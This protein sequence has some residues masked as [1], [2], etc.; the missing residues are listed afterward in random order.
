AGPPPG[1][2][3]DFAAIDEYVEKEMEATRLPGV[4]LGIVRGDEIVHLEG[5]GEADPSGRPVTPKTPFII[6]STSKSFTALAIMQLVEAGE[7]ELDAPVRRYIP[8]FRVADPEA[9]GRI[10]V[11]HLLN[12]TSGLSTASG[13]AYL[14][15]E[16]SS[17][18]ALEKEV[19]G[20]ST[21]ELTAPVGEVYQY[22]NLNYTTLGLIVQRVSGEPYERYVE[23]HVLDPLNMND[24]FASPLEA[25]RRGLATGHQYW[26]GRPLPFGGLSYNRAATP[27][28]FISSS[29]EDMSHYMIAQLDGGRYGDEELLSQAGIAGLHRP[30]V[31]TGAAAGQSYAMG[32]MVQE[33][34]GVSTVWH[35]GS[36]QDFH[37]NVI[38]APERGWGIVLL[39]NGDNLLQ[40]QRIDG[41][42]AGVMSLLVGD[43]PP[44][45]PFELLRTVFFAVLAICLLQLL[46][47]ARSVVLLRRWRTQPARRPRG[48]LRVG[49]RVVG[50][51]LSNLLWAAVCL[52]GLPQGSPLWTM[53]FYDIGLVVVASGTVALVWGAISRPV[54]A[55]LVLR[56][57]DGG[58]AEIGPPKE[59]RAPVEAK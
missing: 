1:E 24:S 25:E 13:T 58:P 7:V 42:A 48:L 40:M 56:T 43:R 47:I 5:F 41:I 53:V 54:L 15:E 16:D 34:N 55:L 28:G 45:A 27:A 9:S 35:N 23:E 10:T 49:L 18:A 17:D 29:A 4:A 51:L 39:T 30:A 37:A 32:W 3:S 59:T 19:R 33:V 36:T 21:V 2:A 26:F 6:G 52:V 44:P 20:L 31:E 22:S 8:W 57:K 14:Y 50:P 12:Q 46:G 38:L 11:R